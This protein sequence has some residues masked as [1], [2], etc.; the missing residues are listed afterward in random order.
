MLYFKLFA[1]NLQFGLSFVH[2]DEAEGAPPPASAPPGR[3]SLA[4]PGD[5]EDEDDFRPGELFAQHR[6]AAG[7]AHSSSADTGTVHTL[8]STL[9]AF[10]IHPI[11]VVVC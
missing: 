3:V 11:P 9:N 2:V 8:Y 4:L 5:S 1:L 7:G 6:Q 10:F